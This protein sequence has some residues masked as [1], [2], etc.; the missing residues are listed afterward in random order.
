M[1]SFLIQVVIISLSGVMAPGPITVAT[2]TAGLRRP[3]SGLLVAVGHGIIEIPLIFLLLVGLGT[4]VQF[5]AAQ[6]TIGLAG[7][8]FLIWLG[9][10]MFNDIY[11]LDTQADSV[12]QA[13]RGPIAIG[14]VLSA[15]NPY[16]LLW[17]ATVGLNLAID[18]TELGYLAVLLFALVHWLC[19]VVWLWILSYA[20]SKGTKILSSRNQK[21]ILAFCSAAIIF[22]GL[23]FII[24]SANRLTAILP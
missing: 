5:P 23:K 12:I 24:S 9:R 6:I 2:I 13:G 1:F 14:L 21:I 4:V 15:T 19:D 8:M 17:W 11:A 18:A 10:G 22:F 16:F 20:S 7:G 3:H